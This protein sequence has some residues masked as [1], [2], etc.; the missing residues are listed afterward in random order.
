MEKSILIKLLKE[1]NDEQQTVIKMKFL[2]ELDNSTIA[3]I[4]NKTE[5]AIRVIQH[6]AISKLKELFDNNIR[7]L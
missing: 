7:K 6:R 1:L 2:E 5:G 3:Q 4:L